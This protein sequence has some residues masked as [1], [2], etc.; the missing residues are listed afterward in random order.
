MTQPEEANPAAGLLDTAELASVLQSDRFKHVLDQA[1]IGI[2]VAELAPPE[3]IVYANAEFE[4]LSG[5][6]AADII[7][8]GWDALEG[9]AHGDGA[10]GL[11]QRA[12]VEDSDHIGAFAIAG[13]SATLHVDA[14]SNQI[15]D[16][17]GAPVF[18]LVALA[19]RATFPEDEREALERT[20]AVKD[21]QLRELQHRVKN[22]LQMIT[23]LIRFE[24]RGMPDGGAGEPFERLAGRVGALALLYRALS[25][26]GGADTVDLGIYLSEIASAVMRAHAVAGIRLDLKVDTWPVSINIAM[27]TGLVVNELLTNSLKHAFTGRDGGEIRL[28]S[29]VDAEGCR[30]LVSDDGVGLPVGA[31]WPTP[32]K[33][34]ALFVRSLAQNARASLQVTSE[35]GRGVAVEIHFAR[36]AAGADQSSLKTGM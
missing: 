10:G 15:E 14:W 25:D 24:A 5:L 16:E 26:G 21:L 4:R 12:I 35:P 32:G 6:A 30:V 22:N 2:A 28:H 7:G 27:P 36:P 18:R 20:L 17:D 19:A 31:I 33:L 3:R 13:D 1:P 9:M 8:K 29:L 23:S 34:S 11:L